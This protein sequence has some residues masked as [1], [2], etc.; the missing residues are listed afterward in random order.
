MAGSDTAVV[1]KLVISEGNVAAALTQFL[2]QMSAIPDDE[3]V[4][5]DFQLRRRDNSYELVYTHA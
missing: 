5:D 4:G 3:V 2:H 1:R